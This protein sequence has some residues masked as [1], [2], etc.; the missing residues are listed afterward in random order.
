MACIE[1]PESQQSKHEGLLYV[2]LIIL[3]ALVESPFWQ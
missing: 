2:T 3:P 1:E